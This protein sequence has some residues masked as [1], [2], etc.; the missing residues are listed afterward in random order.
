MN[1]AKKGMA[2]LVLGAL[3][4]VFGD[5]GTSPL[6][7]LHAIFG[8]VGQHLPINTGNIY[9]IISLVIWSVILVVSV[10]FIGFIMRADNEG[11]GGIMALVARIKS[12]NLNKKYKWLFILFGLVGVSLFYGDSV[13][14]PAIS[15]L[16][17]IEGLKVVAPSLTVYILPITLVI[18]A[19]LFGIQR[20]GTT[21]IGKLFG[22]VMCVWFLA[23][24]LGG[25]LQVWQH[26][27]ILVSLSPLSAIKFFV[28]QPLVAFISMGAVILVITGAEALYADMG[29]FGREPIARAWFL[30]VF[31]ALI[32]CYMG[33][34]ALILHDPSSS[35]SPFMLLFPS[36][37]RLIILVLATLATL[38]ASQA[39]ISGAFSLTRQAVQLNFLPRLL[40]RH[41]SDREVGQVY[42]PF[43]NFVL[44]VI[45]SSLV[46]LFGTSAR[47]TNAYG[48]AV[49]GTLAIDTMLFIVVARI[50]WQKSALYITGTL[51]IFLSVDLLFITANI[52]KILHGGWFPIIV[53]CFIFVI[54]HTWL[55]GQKIITHERRSL[56]GPLQ[57]YIDK[58][59]SKKLTIVRVPGNAV[60]I[61]HH[62]GMA[63]L[64][65]HASVEELHELHEKVVVVSVTIANAAHIPE[66]NRAVFNALGYNDGIS[67]L[68]LTYGFH[69]T[70]NIPRTLKTLRHI[71][72][73][74]DFDPE[75]VS[76][77]IS[78]S[79][80]VLTRKQNLAMWRK[81]LYS[82]LARNA[83]SAS[84]YYKLPTDRT[85]EISSLIDL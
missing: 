24:G 31:P 19:F 73:E 43:I 44:F 76:Y 3:G 63:P 28:N 10:K 67:Q 1:S 35:L 4:V 16:S 53:A 2:G 56:E 37:L 46:L 25:L 30:L 42:M 39:V 17:A 78:Q 66:D 47:L 85:I 9:G 34:G 84:D 55:K 57:E 61:G 26:P 36:A 79:K 11:E 70:P 49:S 60:Y 20:Y 51:L 68:D 75:K 22:P 64:A 52:S 21:T 58:V 80:V 40:V 29:H 83:L 6:Y 50:I 54:I 13:I 15:V 72:S 5:I 82:L 18:L 65:L 33:Q 23:I 38:I 45:V 27:D 7:A 69:D 77:F 74:L 81:S 71:N 59:R 41:T 62:I 32:L 14:T 8:P 12:S 48:V